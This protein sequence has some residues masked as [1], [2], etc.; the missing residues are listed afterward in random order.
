MGF[1]ERAFGIDAILVVLPALARDAFAASEPVVL[2]EQRRVILAPLIEEDVVLEPEHRQSRG[3][4]AP[5]AFDV[6]DRQRRDR[7]ETCQIPEGFEQSADPVVDACKRPQH[8]RGPGR[9]QRARRLEPGSDQ[10]G[11]VLVERARGCA[12]GQRRAERRHRTPGQRGLADAGRQRDQ[13]LVAEALLHH[14]VDVSPDVDVRGGAPGPELQVTGVLLGEIVSRGQAP[15]SGRVGVESVAGIAAVG[16]HLAVPVAVAVGG[17]A[18]LMPAGPGQRAR[19]P[20][21]LPGHVAIGEQHRGEPW[22][23]ALLQLPGKLVDV[24]GFSPRPSAIILRLL[25]GCSEPLPHP[26]FVSVGAAR[27]EYFGEPGCKFRY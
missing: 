5:A 23:A 26:E 1:S 17:L 4:V 10:R 16:D 20:V 7:V 14:L 21:L 12:R 13:G 25:L 15:G 27:I 18:P 19:Q 8:A 6:P 2:V 3:K 11:I 9:H 24:R 22:G